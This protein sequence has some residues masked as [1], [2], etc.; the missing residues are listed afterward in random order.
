[1]CA[2]NSLLACLVLAGPIEIRSGKIAR[3][4]HPDQAVAQRSSPKL[5]PDSRRGLTF[6][7]A[8]LALLEL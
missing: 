7:L 8:G 4:D 6:L 3:E 2:E 5:I 1:M